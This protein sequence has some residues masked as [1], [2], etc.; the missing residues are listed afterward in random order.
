[1]A[2]VMV[3]NE[4]CSSAARTQRLKGAKVVVTTFPRCPEISPETTLG[5]QDMCGVSGCVAVDLEFH[6]GGRIPSHPSVQLF[7]SFLGVLSYPIIDT[8]ARL[9]DGFCSEVLTAIGGFAV[10]AP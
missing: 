3:G 1:M 8:S 5:S 10:H 9:G 2:V 6:R 7:V 4:S